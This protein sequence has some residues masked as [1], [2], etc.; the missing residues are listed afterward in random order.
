MM[1]RQDGVPEVERFW[2]GL[3][4]RHGPR[5]S[6][7]IP[8]LLMISDLLGSKGLLLRDAWVEVDFVFGYQGNHQIP[9]HARETGK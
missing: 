3:H 6:T 1:Y 7:S 4:P 8:N 5:G 2:W 9:D